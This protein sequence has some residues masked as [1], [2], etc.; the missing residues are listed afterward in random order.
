MSDDA[1]ISFLDYSNNAGYGLAPIPS[2]RDFEI[3]SWIRACRAGGML[4]SWRER[5]TRV[6]ASVL[7]AFAT[8]MASLA[9]REGG[10]ERI[11]LGLIALSL[12][13][14]RSKARDALMELSL[15]LDAA[16]RLELDLGLLCD[17]CADVLGAEAVSQVQAFLRRAEEDQRI[18]AMGYVLGSDDDGVRYVSTL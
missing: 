9:L 13:G 1:E 17:N 7:Q 6:H 4:A 14:L 3:E 8:R 16:R 15:V 2:P 10:E 12:G 18:E 5:I 11:E